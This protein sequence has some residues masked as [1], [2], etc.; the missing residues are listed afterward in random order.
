MPLPT[1]VRRPATL[2]VAAALA[3]TTPYAG[4]QSCSARSGE[5]AV[6]VVELYT[7]EGCSSCPPADRWLSGL[8]RDPAVVALA[9][10]VNY[11][12]HLGWH[13]RFSAPAYTQRQAEQRAVNGARYNYTPQLVLQGR[14]RPDWPRLSPPLPGGAAAPVM[15]SVS[16]DGR[17]FS[18]EVSSRDGAPP[19]LAGYW[20]ITE[21]GHRSAVTAGENS[22]EKLAHDYVVREFQPVAAWTGPTVRL[23]FDAAGA[24]QPGH[25]RAINLVVTDAATGRP[26]QALRLPC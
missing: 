20:A 8:K 25:P 17:S 4:A 26:V 10:H 6:P 24:A 3:A 9:F 18:A 1:L 13:D 21:D 22:G 16:G 5:R 15:L 7:S 23:R 14:D 19:R 11:W 2:G 12:D